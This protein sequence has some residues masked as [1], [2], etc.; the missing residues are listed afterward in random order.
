MIVTVDGA[1]AND[2]LEGDG[3]PVF[4]PGATTVSFSGAVASMEVTPRWVTL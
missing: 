3:F 1:I 2:R 4:E